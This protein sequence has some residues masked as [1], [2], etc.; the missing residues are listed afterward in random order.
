MVTRTRL[1]VTL[2]VL[3]HK[4]KAK[5]FV[6]TSSVPASAKSLQTSDQT[7][8]KSSQHHEGKWVPEMRI[9]CLLVQRTDGNG[10][11]VMWQRSRM[12]QHVLSPDS[13]V[14][15]H[16]YERVL[17]TSTTARCLSQLPVTGKRDQWMN[18]DRNAVISVDRK[19][20]LVERR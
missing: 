12:Q 4:K 18:R 5:V 2:P 17:K 11:H 7:Y 10:R 15:Y 20:K 6:G 1:N 3:L 13:H 9:W 19:R 8:R 14:G 16:K